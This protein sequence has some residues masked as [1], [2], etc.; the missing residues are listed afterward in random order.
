MTTRIDLGRL[1]GAGAEHE[2]APGPGPGPGAG[3]GRESA[4]P[5]RVRVSRRAAEALGRRLES[6]M[7]WQVAR[8]TGPDRT[9]DGS[10]R[11][12]PVPPHDPDD[13]TDPWEELGGLGLVDASGRLFP[14][15]PGALDVLARP[16]TAVD[17]DLVVRRPTTGAAPV[18]APGDGAGPGGSTDVQ[19]RAWHRRRA[20]R[21]TAVATA[22]AQ[23]EIGWF[24]DRSWAAELARVAAV[25]SAL[26]PTP[27]ARDLTLPHE[28]MLGVG[29][30]RRTDAPRLTEELLRRH[31]PHMRV[32][33]GADAREQVQLL[34]SGVVGRLRAVVSGQ[35]DDGRR[36]VGW[37]SWLLFSDG[38]RTL[39]PHVDSGVSQVGVHHVEP[40]ALGRE[41]ARLVAGVTS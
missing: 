13:T 29:V 40:S 24:D 23:V 34:H 30:A 2:A 33:E 26:A 32:P 17:L 21:V 35:G 9:L 11:P 38:W 31:L 6:P 25:T 3:A 4:D 5:R 1:D 15:L 39:R 22:G 16:E 7:P 18:A 27:P 10:M 12:A 8:R 41:V 19:L 36:K 28:L 14:E 20:G 37:V